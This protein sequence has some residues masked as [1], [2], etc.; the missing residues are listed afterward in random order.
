LEEEDEDKGEDEE[1]AEEG[2]GEEEG[3]GTETEEVRDAELS[4]E[5]STVFGNE[6]GKVVEEE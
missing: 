5:L 6:V 3:C 2:E 4:A 1:V